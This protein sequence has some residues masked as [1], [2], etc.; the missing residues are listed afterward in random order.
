MIRDLLSY[1]LKRSTMPLKRQPKLRL[2]SIFQGLMLGLLLAGCASTQLPFTL[3]LMTNSQPKAVNLDWQ[4]LPLAQPGA[5]R[6]SGKTDLP[7]QT[8]LTILAMR[9]LYP[10][11]AAAQALNPRP[12]YSI[13]DYQSAV[14]EQGSW[15]TQLNLWQV[16]ADGSFQESWQIDPRQFTVRF[17]P[18]EQVIFLVT[19][20]PIDQIVSL[21]QQLL[22]KGQMLSNRSIR[23]ANGESYVQFHQSQALPLPS[24][25]TERPPQLEAENFGW[26]RRYLMP[27]EPQ[28]PTQL[29]RP[30]QPQTNA[31]TRPEE[32]LR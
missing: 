23:S 3:P 9:Y 31:P 21:Q 6:L 29:E 1:S 14:V 2:S 10:A 20:A 32:F 27:Q 5:Y 17:A 4:T 25:G 11:A 22:A 13:L 12:T 16:G 8:E 18:T 7:D 24:G 19:L 26:G 30:T 28:N 15:Q